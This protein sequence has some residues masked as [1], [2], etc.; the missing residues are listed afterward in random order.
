[1]PMKKSLILIVMFFILISTAFAVTMKYGS[2]NVFSKIPGTRIYV[3][4][5]VEGTESAQIKELQAGTHFL[6]VTSGEAKTETTLYAE[7][8]EIEAGELTTVYVTDK[9][10]EGHKKSM[11]SKEDVDVFKT[12]RV[13]DYSKEMHMG[14]YIKPSYQSALYYNFDSPSLDYYASSFGLGLGFKIPIAPGIDFSLEMERT[15]LTSSKTSWYLMPITANFQIS[16]LPSP[17]FRGKQFFGL[18]LGYYMTDLET[19]LKQNLTTLGYHLFYG[20]EMPAGDKNAFFFE[21][22]YH[23][24]DLSRYNYTLNCTYASVGYRWDV[25]E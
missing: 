16:Y 13:L 21:F 25:M 2:L 10:M 12:K 7:I 14:W 19:D 3:D 18:G 23:V 22:G 6:K 17:Y 8:V 5:K 20:L 15:Q 24:A 4:G 9:G 1:M 11:T